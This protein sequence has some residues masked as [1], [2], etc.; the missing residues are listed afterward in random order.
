M[1]LDKYLKVQIYLLKHNYHLH[2]SFTHSKQKTS[3]N[4]FKMKTKIKTNLMGEKQT[5]TH[6]N[7]V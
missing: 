4:D 1:D 3:E 5:E 2:L 7:D 6:E